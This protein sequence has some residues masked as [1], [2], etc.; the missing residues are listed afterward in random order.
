[1]RPVL[2]ALIIVMSIT[3]AAQASLSSATWITQRV[4]GV[5]TEGVVILHV[6][7]HV[8]SYYSYDVSSELR[9]MSRQNGCILERLELFGSMSRDTNASGDWQTKMRKSP[10]GATAKLLSRMAPVV[11]VE[12]GLVAMKDG[13][14]AVVQDDVWHT[15]VP[16]KS[17][18]AWENIAR[19]K[20][21]GDG[22]SGFAV[23]GLWESVDAIQGSRLVF[24][25]LAPNET[26]I[27]VDR[28]AF[29]VPMNLS[30]VWEFL[31]QGVTDA[32]KLQ[33]VQPQPGN[34]Q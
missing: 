9:I 33:A 32:K 27:D 20:G 16:A 12:R 31:G 3:G 22:E 13:G 18:A 5:V 11:P 17:I 14:L 28:V 24:V 6:Q 30:K 25:E 8:S 34:C 1:M 21:M 4:L 15:V 7:R 2:C 29:V 26:S 19:T 10:N 23:Q